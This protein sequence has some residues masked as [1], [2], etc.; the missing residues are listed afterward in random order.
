MTQCQTVLTVLRRGPV[1]TFELR[2]D[3]YIANPSQRVAELEAHGHVITAERVR[4]RGRA[5]GCVY[6]L[7]HDAGDLEPV[8]VN[9]PVGD[10]GVHGDR[11]FDSSPATLGAYETETAA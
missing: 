2:R 9:V 1:H 8:V 4:L 6:K 11:L 5:Y 10:P 7:T 3:Y